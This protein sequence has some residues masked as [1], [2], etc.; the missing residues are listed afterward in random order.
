MI[1]MSQESEHKFAGVKCGIL[2]QYASM[3]GKQDFGLLL[4][5]RTLKSEAFPLRLSGYS[6]LLI[7]TNVSLVEAEYNDRRKT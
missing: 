2:D 5:C 3:F 1:F 7:N 4:D 6:M